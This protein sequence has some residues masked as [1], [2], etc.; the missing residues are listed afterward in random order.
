MPIQYSGKM[1]GRYR[2][3]L[4]VEGK[5][6]VELKAVKNIVKRGHLC[7]RLV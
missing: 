4:V 5:I 3:D 7:V 2:I 1:V 6:I